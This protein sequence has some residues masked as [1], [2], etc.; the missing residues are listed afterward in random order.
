MSRS[1]IVKYRWYLLC[2]LVVLL[3]ALSLAQEAPVATLNAMAQQRAAIEEAKTVLVS[4]RESIWAPYHKMAAALK[5]DIQATEEAVKALVEKQ[6]KALVMESL[7]SIDKLEKIVTAY[8]EAERAQGYAEDPVDAALGDVM[9]ASTDA[10]PGLEQGL[11]AIELVGHYVN[12]VTYFSR[13]NKLEQLEKKLALAYEKSSPELDALNTKL[14]QI[15]ESA[16][17]LIPLTFEDWARSV[18]MLPEAIGLDGYD[19]IPTELFTVLTIDLSV[20][21]AAVEGVWVQGVHNSLG[22][23]GQFCSAGKSVL[24]LSRNYATERYKLAQLMREAAIQMEFAQRILAETDVNDLP[25]SAQKPWDTLLA[26]DLYTLKKIREIHEGDLAGA[27]DSFSPVEIP[28]Q[29]QRHLKDI[30]ATAQQQP[31]VRAT[32]ARWAGFV[33]AAKNKKVENF[34]AEHGGDKPVAETISFGRTDKSTYHFS[35]LAADDLTAHVLNMP[36]SL[37]FTATVGYRLY[38]PRVGQYGIS[39]GSRW[40]PSVSGNFSY[41]YF[42]RVK[43]SEYASSEPG[44]ATI[45]I[46]GGGL[47]VN[48]A[49]STVTGVS[50][51]FGNL[52]ASLSG[53]AVKWKTEYVKGLPERACPLSTKYN[54]PSFGSSNDGR[55]RTNSYEKGSISD[56]SYGFAVHKISDFTVTPSREDLTLWISNRFVTHTTGKGETVDFNAQVAVESPNDV[57]LYLHIPLISKSVVWKLEGDTDSFGLSQKSKSQ[58]M[59]R[60]L[61]ALGPG[62]VVVKVGLSDGRGGVNFVRSFRV[63]S[64]LG[65]GILDLELP[66]IPQT[67]DSMPLLPIGEQGQYTARLS[68][69]AD[70]NMSQYEMQWKAGWN[71]A[72]PAWLK[73]NKTT[74]FRR[75]GEFWVTSTPFSLTSD[76]IVD[77]Y[78]RVH[79]RLGGY[80]YKKGEA[81]RIGAFTSNR[82]IA[83]T[84]PRVSNMQLGLRGSDSGFI[85]ASAIDL[86][87]PRP[88]ALGDYSPNRLFGFTLDHRLGRIVMGLGSAEVKLNG[89]A[90]FLPGLSRS[91]LATSDIGMGS[92]NARYDTNRATGG[93]LV[94]K[95]GAET[96]QMLIRL[97]KLVVTRE[98][99]ADNA[100]YR[101][102]IYGPSDCTGYTARWHLKKRGQANSAIKAGPGGSIS[103]MAALGDTVTRV[104]LLDV[105]AKVVGEYLPKRDGRILTWPSLTLSARNHDALKVGTTVS[106]GATLHHLKPDLK[107]HKN[108]LS[109]FKVQWEV[110]PAIGRF[111]PNETGCK[112]SLWIIST[113]SRLKLNNDPK[114]AGR[115][116]TIT[117][118]LM[119]RISQVW[120]EIATA[121]LDC[122]CKASRNAPELSTFTPGAPAVLLFNTSISGN[123]PFNP[124]QPVYNKDGTTYSDLGELLAG[125]PGNNDGGGEDNALPEQVGIGCT[126]VPTLFGV[127]PESEQQYTSVSM[128]PTTGICIIIPN[129]SGNMIR[130]ISPPMDPGDDHQGQASWVRVTAGGGTWQF[131]PA[132]AAHYFNNAG[133]EPWT[134]TLRLRANNG[135]IVDI[136]ITVTGSE[137]VPRTLTINS[138]TKVP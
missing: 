109:E 66:D 89:S 73:V 54:V 46:D 10:I 64:G 88:R 14:K 108:A 112:T 42:T 90:R 23:P 21:T 63:V 40:F 29:L 62:A 31:L 77:N 87:S 59:Q 16:K 53:A 93:R 105:E 17:T 15:D 28:T 102:T 104:E 103:E 30:R 19:P 115:R 107:W 9:G 121:T 37:P 58:P 13:Q 95:Q 78:V 127:D 33:T 70:L 57:G 134:T 65:E 138:M 79:F 80:L 61:T 6:A 47:A 49:A 126:G 44:Q 82:R 96:D 76:A 55:P 85:R 12:T 27:T 133:G 130:L 56:R 43:K 60:T 114:L 123:N 74:S 5:N 8:N 51:G 50:M 137:S 98:G 2:T 38:G 113:K 124:Q 117:A 91:K 81:R 118:R 34:A 68:G 32:M 97:N 39:S 84:L 71:T 136:N 48:P 111:D 86:F 132:I 45:S 99:D 18:L 52:I 25:K 101:L 92:I 3:P 72:P 36:R 41:S 22:T 35:N 116:F 110:D 135:L 20:L 125:G 24:T 131:D 119:R 69:P 129:T 67:F 106:V 4:Y 94:L 26:D 120:I 7:G 122:T 83:G 11:D 100:T 1:I 128:D 75:E